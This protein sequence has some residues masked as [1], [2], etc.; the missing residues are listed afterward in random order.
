MGS[1]SSEQ[2]RRKNAL[3]IETNGVRNRRCITFSHC[4]FFRN[5]FQNLNV[6]SPAPIMI[7]SHLDS[8]PSMKHD[9]HVQ[10]I[11]FS[12]GDG[13]QPYAVHH[14]KPEHSKASLDLS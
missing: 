12:V 3:N 1:E 7:V 11:I 8:S 9:C 2:Q 4:G 10:A 6:S 13:G 5:A 14:S